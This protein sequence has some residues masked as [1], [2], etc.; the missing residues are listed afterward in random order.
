VEDGLW[1]AL[2]TGLSHSD[3]LMIVVDGIDQFG[4]VASLQFLERLK[5]VCS[6]HEP[7]KAVALS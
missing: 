3:K 6:K 7:I 4:E 5:K 2:D 1:A